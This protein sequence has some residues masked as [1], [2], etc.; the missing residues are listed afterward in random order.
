MPRDT[1]RAAKVVTTCLTGTA[2][3][4]PRTAAGRSVAEPA[5]ASEALSD[6]GGVEAAPMRGPDCHWRTGAA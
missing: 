3:E 6:S 1:G 2:G 5:G 4:G